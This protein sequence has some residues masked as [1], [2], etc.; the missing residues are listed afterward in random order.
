MSL[1]H[2]AKSRGW[3]HG[4]VSFWL[5]S[6]QELGVLVLVLPLLWPRGRFCW[7]NRL[8]EVGSEEEPEELL[9]WWF[10][11]SRVWGPSAAGSGFTSSSQWI[12]FLPTSDSPSA[13]ELIFSAGFSERQQNVADSVSIMEKSS[14]TNFRIRFIWTFQPEG[15]SVLWL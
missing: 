2:V 11:R 3:C 6:S 13:S 10:G 7:E 4:F 14:F 15:S 5:V 9:T 12:S 8:G 1:K